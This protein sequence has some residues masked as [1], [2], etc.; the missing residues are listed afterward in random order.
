VHHVAAPR[1]RARE[2]KPGSGGR[3]EATALAAGGRHRCKRLGVTPD[4][5]RNPHSIGNRAPADRGVEI[6]A[7]RLRGLAQT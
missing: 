5:E 6:A 1:F 7:F 2:R 4:A 3:T